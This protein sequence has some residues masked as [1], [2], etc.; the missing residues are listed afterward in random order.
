M[1]Q[2]TAVHR[3]FTDTYCIDDMFKEPFKE[4]GSILTPVS[5]RFLMQSDNFIMLCHLIPQIILIIVLHLGGLYSNDQHY[6]DVCKC[7][8][9]KQIIV[10]VILKVHLHKYFYFAPK[11]N[12]SGES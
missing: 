11:H 8:P 7:L 10:F 5:S 2:R 4:M 1:P 6:A 3:Q 9:L 12:V